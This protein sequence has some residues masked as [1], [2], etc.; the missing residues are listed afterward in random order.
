LRRRKII[1]IPKP[2]LLLVELLIFT[3][4][5]VVTRDRRIGSMSQA[6][7]RKLCTYNATAEKNSQRHEQPSGF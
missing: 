5:K 6:F 3:T 2:T 1:F 4:L 7:D